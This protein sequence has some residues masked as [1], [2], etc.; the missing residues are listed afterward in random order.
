LLGK[1]LNGFL[2]INW[3]GRFPEFVTTV[4]INVLPGDRRGPANP[5]CPPFVATAM[6]MIQ[7]T[8]QDGG[9][10]EDNAVGNQAA[11]LAPNLLF[12]FGF[13][14][15][16]PEIGIGNGSAKLMIAFTTIERLLDI[17]PQRR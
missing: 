13:K 2:H 16:L 7:K 4:E 17:A 8:G 9:V 5:V 15:Q 12:V 10:V 14:T 3:L 11:A 1:F 6:G